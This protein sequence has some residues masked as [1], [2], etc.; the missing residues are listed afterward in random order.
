MKALQ[1]RI[2]VEVDMYQKYFSHGLATGKDYDVNFRNK[3]PV[4]CKCLETKGVLKKGDFLLVHHNFFYDDSPYQ[5]SGNIFSIKINQNIFSRLDKDGNATSIFGN[6]IAERLIVPNKL[7]MPDDYKRYYRD[8]CKVISDGEGF[9]KENIVI[10]LV[11]GDYEIIYNWKGEE[12]TAI[13]IKKEEI[14]GKML[15]KQ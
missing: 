7:E 5:V 9:R 11:H 14:V 3:R 4:M 2:L 6:V 12:R 13:K 8:R 10:H 1:H 15:K